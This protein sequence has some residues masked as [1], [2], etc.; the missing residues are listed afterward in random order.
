M[1]VCRSSLHHCGSRPAPRL[2][3]TPERHQSVFAQAPSRLRSDSNDWTIP[4]I[5]LCPQL[6]NRKPH[7]PHGFHWVILVAFTGSSSSENPHPKPLA[8]ARYP[9]RS[10]R[11]DHRSLLTRKRRTHFHPWSHLS[12]SRNFARS[13]RSDYFCQTQAHHWSPSSD[14]LIPFCRRTALTLNKPSSS[15]ALKQPFHPQDHAPNLVVSLCFSS[16]LHPLEPSFNPPS[17]RPL[18]QLSLLNPSHWHCGILT[19]HS[20]RNS[21]P[22]TPHRWISSPRF[23][24][25][26]STVGHALLTTSPPK[27]E[28]KGEGAEILLTQ[29]RPNTSNKRLQN[30]LNLNL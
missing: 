29:S 18:G 13:S 2:Q 26:L 11:S 1:V 23:G 20:W 19:L 24:R 12:T 30:S 25:C 9:S 27:N 3:T 21:H 28:D 7:Q 5:L 14:R 17:S 22:S 16:S 4:V 8:M 10:R 15:D 6:S